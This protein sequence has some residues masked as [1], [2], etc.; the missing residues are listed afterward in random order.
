[1][2]HVSISLRMVRHCA[3]V[4]NLLGTEVSLC[5]LRSK[6]SAAVCKYFTRRPKLLNDLRSNESSHKVS[7]VGVLLGQ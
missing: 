1:M 6:F 4:L 7:I 5:V 3:D 2:F